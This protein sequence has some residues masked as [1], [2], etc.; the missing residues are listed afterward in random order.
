MANRSKRFSKT[1]ET[2]LK[3]KDAIQKALVPDATSPTYVVALNLVRRVA[4]MA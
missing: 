3:A 4:S 2:Q 1:R